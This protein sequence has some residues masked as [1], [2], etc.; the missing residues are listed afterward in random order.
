[1]V[2]KSWL[3]RSVAALALAGVFAAVPA[4]AAI[5]VNGGFETGDFTGWTLTGDTS[6]SFVL[7]EAP[8]PQSGTYGASF[9]PFDT[10][11]GISQS[12]ATIAG[13]TYVLDFWLQAESDA[14]GA[15]APNSFLAQWNGTTVTSLVNSPAF[16]Y[17][18]LIF[19]VTATSATTLLS[20]TF[21]NNPAFWDLDN[22][23]V[24]AVPE[25]ETWALMVLGLAAVAARRRRGSS[26]P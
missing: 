11:G 2:K 4:G 6:Y 19:D 26:R 12:L 20:F 13:T 17:Q 22:V 21:N 3:H 15:S 23:R 16:A 7:A 9:G 10:L 25:P 18:H 14:L 1:M 8:V 5:V 24:T